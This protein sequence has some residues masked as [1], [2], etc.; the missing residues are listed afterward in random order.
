MAFGIPTYSNLLVEHYEEITGGIDSSG[1]AGNYY[2]MY[3]D[4]FLGRLLDSGIAT[5]EKL[6][7]I[8]RQ[9]SDAENVGDVLADPPNLP[10]LAAFGLVVL[11]RMAQTGWGAIDHEECFWLHEQ[12]FECFEY[13][14]DGDKKTAAARTSAKKRHSKSQ[15]AKNFI[16]NE[17]KEKKVEYKNNKSEFARHYVRRI[18]REFDFDVAEKT[19]R[20]VW[21]AD[22]PAASKRAG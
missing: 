1:I 10:T 22:T 16:A 12:L 3:R 21:L 9:V 2:E 11:H 4:T 13:V 14:R 8:Y 7:E 18:K 20:E 19:I 6:E 17:W 5:V 15:A